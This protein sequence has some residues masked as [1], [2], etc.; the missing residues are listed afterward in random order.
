[1]TSNPTPAPDNRR[2]ERPTIA[3]LTGIR[4]LRA[5]AMTR[6]CSDCGAEVGQPCLASDGRELSIYVHP[7]RA[8]RRPVEP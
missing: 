2:R 6:R 3:E 8:Q 1:M 7:V 4:A 5:V